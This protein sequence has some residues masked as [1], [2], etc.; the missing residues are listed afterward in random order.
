MRTGEFIIYVYFNIQTTIKNIFN[1]NWE[2]CSKKGIDSFENISYN[3]NRIKVY[4]GRIL[5]E[6]KNLQIA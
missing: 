4:K 2:I 5:Y 6:T 1:K 3:S